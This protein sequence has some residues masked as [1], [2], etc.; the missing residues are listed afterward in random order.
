MSDIAITTAAVDSSLTSNAHP[1]PITPEARAFN[2][3]VTAAVGKLNSANYAGTGREVSFSIDPA[4]RQ[5]VIRVID[6]DTK[7]VVTQIPAKYV[8][9]LADDYYSQTRDS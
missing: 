1:S 3:S 7:E 6:S 9:D 5:P 4:S 2:V 8:L